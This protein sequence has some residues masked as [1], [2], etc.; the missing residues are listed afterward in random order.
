MYKNAQASWIFDQ[1]WL[2]EPCSSLL[3]AGT[4]DQKADGPHLDLIETSV[5]ASQA[6]TQVYLSWP[7]LPV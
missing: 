3:Q 7:C 6:R 2:Y 4:V 5:T 1:K